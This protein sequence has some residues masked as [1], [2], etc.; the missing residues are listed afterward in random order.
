GVTG[1]AG[2]VIY[3][4][5]GVRRNLSEGRENTDIPTRIS[6]VWNREVSE[7]GLARIRKQFFILYNHIQ[8]EYRV[9]IYLLT[10][11]AKEPDDGLHVFNSPLF[12]VG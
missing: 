11:R 12:R 10:C 8:T 2:V 5:G 9:P 1:T 4:R 6:F 3:Q 7:W